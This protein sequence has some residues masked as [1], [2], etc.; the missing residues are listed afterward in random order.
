M[1]PLVWKH[2]LIDFTMKASRKFHV[3]EMFLFYPQPIFILLLCTR[4]KENFSI[5]IQNK[6]KQDIMRKS[7]VKQHIYASCTNVKKEIAKFENKTTIYNG[8]M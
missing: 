8:V 6:N 3:S 4:L 1:P 5:F 2:L 7:S